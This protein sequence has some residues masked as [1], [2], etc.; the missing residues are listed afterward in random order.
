MAFCL[1]RVKNVARWIW[2]AVMLVIKTM[3]NIFFTSI[4]VC[5]SR[6]P[7]NKIFAT[8]CIFLKC[9][10]FWIYWGRSVAFIYFSSSLICLRVTYK[11]STR[12]NFERT[13]YPV[14]NNFRPTKY[15]REK[16]SDPRRHDDMMARDSWDPPL[17]VTR[18]I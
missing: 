13:K 10:L 12:K 15:P 16:I 4:Y 2:A 6:L 9:I 14:E 1:H 3:S 17:H 8:L 11:I 18:G 5:A 7:S